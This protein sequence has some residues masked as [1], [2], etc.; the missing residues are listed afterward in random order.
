MSD[1]RPADILLVDNSED[2]LIITRRAFQRAGCPVTLHHVRDGGQCLDFLHRRKAFAA[3]PTIELVLL[4]L[5]MTGMDGRST[6]SAITGDA[7]LCH[8][9]VVVLS[10]S[11]YERDVLD[12][13]RLRCS[14]YLTKPIDFEHFTAALKGLYEYWFTVVQR[15]RLP[16]VSGH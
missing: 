8:L 7:A 4:D 13:Y 14:A 10:T 11:D 2:D 16:V 9:P 12:C 6:L 1:P 15:P 5:N 3:A